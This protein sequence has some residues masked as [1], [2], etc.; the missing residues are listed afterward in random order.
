MNGDVTLANGVH[1]AG[2]IETVNGAIAAEGAT[3]DGSVSNYSGGMRIDHS[4]IK[5][6]L[7]VHKPD[8]ARPRALPR[9]VI[10]AESQ[11]PGRLKFERAV[12]LYVHETAQIGPVEGAEPMRYTGESSTRKLKMA[13]SSKTLTRG[14]VTKTPGRHALPKPKRRSNSRCWILRPK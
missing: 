13:R 12:E 7:T 9:I 10:G 14:R 2:N 11:V 8:R 4:V 5:G 3:I 1:V 6:G